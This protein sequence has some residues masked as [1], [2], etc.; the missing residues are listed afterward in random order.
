MVTVNDKDDPEAV[1]DTI[2]L[3][4]AMFCDDNWVTIAPVVDVT[5]APT[6][7]VYQAPPAAQVIITSP[8]EAPGRRIVVDPPDVTAEFA[9]ICPTEVRVF[10]TPLRNAALIGGVEE[11]S[12]KGPTGVYAMRSAR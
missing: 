12:V 4:G 9:E 5:N 6:Y 7:P 1:T 3:P 11:L 2:P 10:S 8:E